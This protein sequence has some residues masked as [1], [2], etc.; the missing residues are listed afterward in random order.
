MK[1]AALK[2]K[3]NQLTEPSRANFGTQRAL[4]NSAIGGNAGARAESAKATG[5]MLRMVTR[6]R[7]QA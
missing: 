3:G 5:K 2:R 7:V 4:M 1:S 6:P